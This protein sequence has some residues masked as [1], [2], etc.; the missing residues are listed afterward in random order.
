MSDYI[1]REDAI[2]HGRWIDT[3]FDGYV[4][5]DAKTADV[6]PVRHGVW[7]PVRWVLNPARNSIM[8]VSYECSECG[9]KIDIWQSETLLDYPYCHCGAKM[10]GENK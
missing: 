2:R 5:E 9:R 10:D 1:K 7:E 8:A 4:I 6:A 3:E